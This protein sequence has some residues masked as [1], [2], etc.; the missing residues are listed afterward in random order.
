MRTRDSLPLIPGWSKPV[1]CPGCREGYLQERS[2]KYG[3]FYGCTRYPDC[4]TTLN[5]YEL[6]QL[7]DPDSD[8]AYLYGTEADIY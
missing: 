1:D 2:G 5:D 6:G 8:E 4:R 3:K 7:L